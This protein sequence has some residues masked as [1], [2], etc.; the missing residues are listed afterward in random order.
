MPGASRPPTGI[1][2]SRMDPRMHHGPPSLFEATFDPF[3]Q[4]E[5]GCVL[6]RARWL[7]ERATAA[8][9]LQ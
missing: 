6:G 5:A 3:V 7:A 2:I 1:G 4:Q 8:I 9:P